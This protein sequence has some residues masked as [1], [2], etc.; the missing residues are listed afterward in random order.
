M[1]ERTY[2][3][4][5]V[6]ALFK[7]AAELQAQRDPSGGSSDTRH[8]LTLDELRAIAADAGLDPELLRVAAADIE[9]PTRRRNPASNVSRREIAV[10]RWIPGQLD[11]LA[12]EDVIAELRHRFEN[13]AA[14]SMGM[15][16]LGSSTTQTIGRSLEWQYV[17]PWWG[18]ETRVLI[19]P[20]D[21]ELRARVTRRNAYSSTSTGWSTSYG[22]LFALG[23]LIIT[24][25]LFGSFL[26]GLLIALLTLATIT[27]LMMRVSKSAEGKHLRELESVTEMIAAHA[28]PIP[29]AEVEPSHEDPAPERTR[30]EG[31]LALDIPEADTESEGPPH[32][33]RVRHRG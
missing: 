10:E 31:P 32:S 12:K 22:P 19:Q 30:R 1:P 23:A 28:T 11:D 26:I 2:T 17:D 16:S 24:A 14:R 3:E 21:E 27:P 25:P 4:E 9:R 18:T 15:Y 5:E 7:R 8:G 33:T 13:S 20:R 29:R 6:A